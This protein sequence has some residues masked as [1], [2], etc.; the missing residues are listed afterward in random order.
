MKARRSHFALLP[1]AQAKQRHDEPA[2][3]QVITCS[4]VIN[5]RVNLQAD[6]DL[7]K[8]TGKSGQ[9]V[10]VAA[11]AAHALDIHGQYKNAGIADFSLELLDANG[12][13]LATAE[14][15]VGFDPIIEHTLPADGDYTVRS[16]ITQLRRVPRSRSSTG[17]GDVPYPARA[18]S[19]AG[20]QQGTDLHPNG[21]DRMFRQMW[22]HPPAEFCPRRSR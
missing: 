9:A 19:L 18:R 22:Q 14:D 10:T 4:A 11:I 17:L 1:T 2:K 15:T 20:F 6:I 3:A 21:S 13:T 12:R 8:I 16:H 5:G 7:F